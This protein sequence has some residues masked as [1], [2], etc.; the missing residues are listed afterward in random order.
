MDKTKGTVGYSTGPQLISLI[1]LG[2]IFHSSLM[3]PR[4]SAGVR[5]LRT[6]LSVSVKLAL[7]ASPTEYLTLIDNT[8][9]AFSTTGST[10][11][12]GLLRTVN[13]M[14]IFRYLTS[15]SVCHPGVVSDYPVATCKDNLVFSLTR[16]TVSV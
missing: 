4:G 11:G 6:P 16:F 10:L 1:V 14:S 7:T 3:F 2:P 5:V 12:L 8:S 13:L 15:H 9:L